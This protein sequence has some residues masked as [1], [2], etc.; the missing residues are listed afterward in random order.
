[1]TQYA[2]E[3]A[4]AK[5]VANKAGRMTLRGFGLTTAA[6]WKADNTPLTETDTAVNQM[7]IERVKKS[8][9]GDGVL[10]EE[11]SYETERKRL[12]VVDPVDGTQPFTLGAPVST[13]LLALVIEGQPVLGIIYDMYQERMFWAVQGGG[14][15][16]N[17]ARIHVSDSE[18]LRR[19]YMILS[20]RMGEE[21]RSTGQ[22]FDSIEAAGGKSF[23]FRSFAYGSAF[24]AAGSAVGAVIGVPNA[25]DVAATKIIVEEA[26][27][28]VTDITGND[29][30]Y[31]GP[32]N[33]L[34]AT[35]GKVHEQLLDMITA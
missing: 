19:N 13:F 29:R 23:N 4:F 24:V 18:T 11:A 5:D 15:Y 32:G 21:C 9:P 8:F 2:A 22:L 16:L 17:D 35:N 31:D 14:A 7:V 12:W 34:L 3:I 25:W 6:T 28:K 27:G 26:G 30:R 1:M 20:S 10:G 33:G